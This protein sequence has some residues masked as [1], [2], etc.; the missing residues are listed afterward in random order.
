MWKN[1]YKPADWQKK[2]FD[3]PDG[4]HFVKIIKVEEKKTK[5]NNDMIEITMDVQDSNGV[6]YVERI[7]AG[8]YFDRNTT[9][10]FDVFGI[11]RGNFNYAQW[12]QRKATAHF[13]HKENQFTDN[14][15]VLHTFQKSELIYY[16][17][18]QQ[19]SGGYIPQQNSGSGYIRQQSQPV[20]PQNNVPEFIY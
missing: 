7:V 17:M 12:L 1:D 3:C 11:Q 8:E 4:D 13:E 10:I 18:P 15:G 16:I 2:R 9:R 20:N 14:D 19:S 5:D 6:N